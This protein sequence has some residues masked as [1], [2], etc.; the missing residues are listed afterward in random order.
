MGQTNFLQ[1]LP[2]APG[3][4]LFILDAVDLH[5]LFQNPLHRHEGREC[6]IWVLHVIP[7]VGAVFLPTFTYQKC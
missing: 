7:D 3:L 2:N 1:D 6:A 4:F 5:G